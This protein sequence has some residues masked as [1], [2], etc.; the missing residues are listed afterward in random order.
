MVHTS[1]QLLWSS[2]GQIVK[3]LVWVTSIYRH[4][5]KSQS[6]NK[7]HKLPHTQAQLQSAA[8]YCGP[9]ALFF[10]VVNQQPGTSRQMSRLSSSSAAVWILSAGVLWVSWPGRS[11]WCLPI[12]WGGGVSRHVL[13][14]LTS[15][16]FLYSKPLGVPSSLSQ[17]S[18]SSYQCK[19][20]CSYS[21]LVNN[22]RL[23]L[24]WE[25]VLDLGQHGLKGFPRFED[26]P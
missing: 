1:L 22:P 10:R 21:G 16:A 24:C 12:W 11:L 6:V 18:W 8:L 17:A 5:Q 7:R 26:Y 9:T 4:A 15:P 20:S 19:S 2:S 3:K 25:C 23:F 13:L 14:W